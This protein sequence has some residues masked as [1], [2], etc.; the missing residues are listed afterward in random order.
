MRFGR[1]LAAVAMTAAVAG[2]ALVAAPSA[3]AYDSG[4]TKI[5]CSAV[6]VHKSYS[7]TSTVRGIAYK[8]DKMTYTQWVH[9]KKTNTWWTRGTV[10]RRSDGVKI[11]G[12]V[13]YNCANPYGTNPA[14]KPS[15]PK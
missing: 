5:S 14:P 15:I 12:Y 13:I 11:S 4:T 7:T 3:Q 10:K 9:V 8:G 2:A 6:K 1:P